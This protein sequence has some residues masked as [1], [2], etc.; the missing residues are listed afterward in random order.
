MKKSKIF[1]FDTT[2]RDGEQTPGASLNINEKV[3]IATQLDALGVDAIEAGFPCSSPG[4]FAAV[5]AVAEH[6]KR[7]IICGLARATKKDI[8]A[9]AEALK[10][11]RRPRIHVFIATSKIHRQYKLHKTKDEILRAS[12]DAVKYAR[13]RFEDVEFS[14]EDAS[15]T[16]LDFLARMVEA[17][18]A[19][20][21][22]TVNIPDTV[23]YALPEEFASTIRYLMNTVPNIG[24]AVVSVHCHNDLGLAVSNSI[25]AIMNGARQVECTLNG[26]GER[27]G[28]A[29]LEEIVMALKVRKDILG[30]MTTDIRTKELLKTSRLVSKLTGIIV[31]PNKAI[32]GDNAFS[33]EAGIHQDGILK[34]RVTY[35]IIRPQD[36]GCK[37]S[38][39]VL[40][41]LSGRHA[42]SARLK[43]LGYSLSG[44]ELDQAFARF[45]NLADKK[46]KIYDDDLAMIVEAELATIPEV[47]KLID[48]QVT[49]GNNIRPTANIELVFEKKKLRATSSGD[50]TVDACFKTIDKAI[51]IK[52]RLVDYKVRAVTSGKDALGEANVK[53]DFKGKLVI[54][55]ASSTDVIEASVLAYVNAINRLSG[56]VGKAKSSR[57]GR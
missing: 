57:K 37:G 18:I 28:N 47:Y 52:G 44:E 4:D 39:L 42:F 54:G 17:V 33:H 25:A 19:A 20:G 11:A 50:G 27:A 34:K 53:I 24:K 5:G 40:G 43:T 16:E 56:S 15:R 21:A 32:V 51:G 35:E 3:Q 9:A 10:K 12:V 6:V 23:G 7:P 29:A 14:P 45:K 22:K 8:D 2:L 13:K 30:G 55:R 46:A 41:K 31:Q 38:T 36:I 26:L 48:F 1:V 49:S